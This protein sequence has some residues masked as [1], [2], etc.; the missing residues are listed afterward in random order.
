M[1]LM[2]N[3]ITCFLTDDSFPNYIVAKFKQ[4]HE[5]GEF[6]FRHSLM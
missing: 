5:P 4:K 1:K 6:G 2:S 3:F